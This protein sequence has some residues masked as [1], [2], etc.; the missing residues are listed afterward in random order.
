MRP[1]W[2]VAPAAA[3]ES[4]PFWLLLAVVLSQSV[5][6]SGFRPTRDP[7]K[8]FSL[9]HWESSVRVAL[10]GTGV[11]WEKSSSTALLGQRHAASTPPAPV[12]PFSD[13]EEA[14]FLALGAR[15]W[16][17]AKARGELSAATKAA[18]STPSGRSAL[19]AAS[20]AAPR[21]ALS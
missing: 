9:S 1:K 2:L 5:K 19:A 3:A 11:S 14:P 17:K 8:P 12:L 18:G 21:A 4:L 6:L 13:D 15:V 7:A 16:A 20:A 10:Q